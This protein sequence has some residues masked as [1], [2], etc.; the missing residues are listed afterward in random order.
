MSVE[1]GRGASSPR[2]ALPFGPYEIV[3]QLRPSRYA[4]RY[5]A[6]QPERLTHHVA[7]LFDLGGQGTTG[8][9]DAVSRAGMV[10]STHVLP[11]EQFAVLSVDEAWAISP[12]LGD[13]DGLLLLSDLVA[14]KGGVLPELETRRAVSQLLAAADDASR[15]GVSHGPLSLDEVQID[16]RGSVHIELYGLAA[17]LAGR[18]DG[19]EMRREEVRSIVALAYQCLTGV[20]A[21]DLPIEASRLAEGLDP[22]WDGFFRA[23]LD[24][25]WGFA[26]PAEALEALRAPQGARPVIEVRS[27]M[28]GRSR[29]SIGS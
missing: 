23:G 6:R 5:L 15:S 1:N 10:V 24:P 20:P 12:Y 2:T 14:D 4:T 25:A 26:S 18:V 8:F 21:E 22:S 7:Y 13:H 16:R 17:S 28:P 11:I 27:T 19:D 9:L 29:L 3:R